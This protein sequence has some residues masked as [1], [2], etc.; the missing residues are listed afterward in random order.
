M[1]VVALEENEVLARPARGVALLAVLFLLPTTGCSVKKFAVNKL[2]DS[3]A[4]GGDTFASDND[5][6]LVGQALPFSLK[7]MDGLPAESLME[8]GYLTP[9]VEINLRMSSLRFNKPVP[10]ILRATLPVI[11]VLAIGVLLIT[12]VPALTTVVPRGFGQ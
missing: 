6:D 12:C 4:G 5:P 10:E 8:L 1:R 9:P 3:L 7:L 2:G 11:A